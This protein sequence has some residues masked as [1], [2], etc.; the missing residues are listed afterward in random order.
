[1]G[2][3]FFQPPS[4]GDQHKQQGSHIMASTADPI[5]PVNRVFILP[6]SFDPLELLPRALHGFA[7]DAR[8]V[9]SSILR[10]TAR[11]QADEQG[12]VPLRAEYLRNVISKR[13][14]SEIV[15]SLVAAEAIRRMPYQVGVRSFAYRLADRYQADQHIRLPIECKRML[16]KLEAH[17]AMCKAEADQRMKPVHVTL[18]RLQHGLEIDSMESA[19]ILTTL[20]AESNP[21][22]VQGVMIQDIL[23]QR[24][25]LSVGQYG[26][27]AN[28]I[29][30]MKREIRTA[31]RCA[32]MPL[33]GVDISCAQPCLL[34]LFIRSCQ[35]N[36][37]SYI[38][39]PLLPLLPCPSLE[40]FSAAC[41]TGE[42]FGILGMRLLDA[43]VG[44]S[45]DQVK[46]RFLADV[47]AK[48]GDYPSIIEDIFRAEW[49]GVWRFIRTV[50]K[51]DHA[52]LIRILQ[53]LEAWLVIEQVCDRFV[54][55]WPGEFVI[56][57]HDAAYC[58]P[59]M[60]GA[61]T[62]SFEDVFDALDFRPQLKVEGSK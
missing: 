16:R 6:E 1:V 42:L 21:F 19:A 54:R 24:Y 39:T 26:R 50:N 49:P 30:S 58:R 48:R 34:S 7:D 47:L 9:V 4:Q 57:I 61:L 11:G 33:A 28:S 5:K 53:Q 44:W 45:R 38:T 56:T 13:K 55:R 3:T 40:V 35:R 12:Y 22:D 27:V 59:E 17:A 37:P 8:Y 46:K 60:L 52:T 14:C 15:K 41:L 25:R 43:G 20:T 31:L 29:T 10:K 51:D 32:G 36:V 23:E 18:A 62:E 2:F